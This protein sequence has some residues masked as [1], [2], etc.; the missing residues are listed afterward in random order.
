MYIHRFLGLVFLGI[1]SLF[2]CEDGDVH[3]TKSLDEEITIYPDYKDV[4]IPVNIA[5]LNFSVADS[6]EYCLI[7]KGRESQIQVRSD[8]GLFVIPQREWKNLLSE[9]AG[10]EIELT[11]AKLT[12][13][14]WNAY[15]PFHIQVAKDS[16]D[17]YIAYRLLALSNMWSKMGIYQRDLESYE[18]S[19]I[20]ENSLTGYNCVNCHSFPSR[21]PKKLVFHMRGTINGSVLIDGKKVTKLNTK[22]PETI[23]N[24][25]YMYM[26]PSGDFLAATVC[27]T[28]QNFFVNNPNT[29]EVQDDN[30][31][32]VIYDVERNEIF[33]CESLNSKDAW[34]IYP[35]FS[36]DGKSLYFCATAA[37]DS[38]TKNFW[39]TNYSL[40][41]IDFDAETRTF[42]QQ[43]DTLYNGRLN[44]KSVSFPRVSPDGKYLAFTLQA[45]GSFGVWHTDADLY[46]VRLSDGEV[47]PLTEAN[48]PDM[49]DSYHSWSGNSHWL[50]FS[51][52]RIDGLYTCP[53]FTYI[54]EEGQAHKPFLLPQKNPVKYY[55]DLMLTY[56]LPEFIEGKVQLDKHAILKTMRDTKG[57]QVQ[58]RHR[59]GH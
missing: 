22:T 5:P 12:D 13:G 41:R 26:H 20:Y 24:F 16:I 42:G 28:Y 54:D 45:Y 7:L 31:D 17:P 33:T 9:N 14:A 29:L 27:Q 1:T 44:H 15:T 35:T 32:I 59:E 39:Q 38:V 4:T 49:G 8:E 11:V 52:R 50:V 19:V 46:M 37:V 10:N 3:I 47:Y 21:D 18:Q 55:K 6:S 23:S 30:S 34:Q 43:V 51:S 36:P 56:N 48:S 2:S 53:F 40:C 25:S 57:V 58:V